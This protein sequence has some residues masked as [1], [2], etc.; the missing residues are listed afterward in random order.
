MCEK[1]NG[2]DSRRYGHRIGRRLYGR[3][4]DSGDSKE[5]QKHTG[6]DTVTRYAQSV[7]PASDS[8]PAVRNDG[9]HR[10]S[11]RWVRM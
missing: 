8:G 4:P 6:S 11:V 2:T 5:R 9:Y 3:A 1:G 7:H 10:Y